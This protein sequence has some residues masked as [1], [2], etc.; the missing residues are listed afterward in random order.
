MAQQPQ[1]VLTAREGAVQALYAT[2][3]QGA[4][5]NIQLKQLLRQG[6]DQRERAFCT[7]LTYGVLQTSTLLEH[8]L[9]AF[10]SVPLRKLD[11]YIKLILLTA[12]YQILYLER[13]PDRAACDEAVKLARRYARRNPR[14][15]GYVNA[16]LRAVVANRDA[17]PPLNEPTKEA[18]WAKRYALPLWLVE[19]WVRQY[20]RETAKA[21][22]E[23]CNT[24]RDT[25][26]R[27]NTLRASL[28]QVQ[29]ELEEQGIACQPVEGLPE[30]LRIRFT[31]DM[32]QLPAYRE[33][34]LTPQ[35][36]G[37][38]IAVAVLA[39]QPGEQVLDL[40]S[41]PGG[42]SLLMAQYM[43]NRGE[44][45]AFDL[46]EHKV[47][48]IRRN[49]ARAGVQ[50]LRAQCGDMI[51]LRPELRQSAHRVL[52]DVPCSGLGIIAKKPDIRYK[53][54][55]DAAQLP[56]IQL[57]IL[58][59]AMEYVRPGGVLVYSTCTLNQEENEAVVQ[60]A[61]RENTHFRPDLVECSYHH[62]REKGWVTLLPHVY[63]SDGFFIARLRRE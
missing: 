12:I 46:H 52:C 51:Q 3:Y 5:S 56:P 59:N 9:A 25:V 21:L 55:E 30:A 24:R 31:G 35:D 19:M 54:Q 20:G 11:P 60:Q 23:G 58:R 53:A 16:V 29:R 50:I 13:V 7:E 18:Y 8:Y 2:L 14:I 41:A 15:A 34:R 49:A 27:V 48:I 43:K 33:G 6:M 38:Q 44:I 28:P 36:V 39:P 40:C 26:V 4:Y 22:C 1:R 63:D 37:S 45:Q 42:K 62:I 61:L 57:A 47:D 32:E 17:L 10:S